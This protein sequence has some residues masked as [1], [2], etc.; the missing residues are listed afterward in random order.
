MKLVD[1]KALDDIAQGDDEIV[2]S[3][4]RYDSVHDS[5]YIFCLVIIVGALVEQ[6]LDDIT[7][8]SGKGFSYFRTGVF[9]TDVAANLHQLV[10]S[11]VIPVVDVFL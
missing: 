4:G 8:I 9:A 10:D 7:E 2:G 3:A 11:D 1:G 5:C 6:F